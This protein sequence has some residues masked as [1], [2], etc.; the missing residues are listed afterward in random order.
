MPGLHAVLSASSSKRWLSCPPS[1][2]LEEKLKGIFGE[3]SSPYAEEGTQAH[4]VAELKLRRANGEINEFSYKAQ[5]EQLGDIPKEMDRA[6]DDYADIVLGKFYAAQK[7]SE[8]AKLLVEQRLDFSPWVPHGFGTG[9]AVIVSDATLEVAD[10]KF[11]K[12]V[13]IVAQ[14]N[15]QARLYGLGA[16]NALGELYGFTHVRNTIIQPRVNEDPVTEETLTREELE[17]W[18]ESIRPTAELAWKGL[19]EYKP[20]DHC[21]FCAARAL[22]AA[23]AAEAMRGFTHGFATPGLIDDADIP[24]ILEVA[25]VAESW[26]RDVRA[27]ARNQALRGQQWAG[28][29]LVR[30]RKG[31]RAWKDEEAVREQLIRAGYTEEQYAVHK[32][33]PPGEIE[34][35]L[36]KQAFSALVAKYVTQADGALNLVPESDKRIEFAAADADFS[37]MA[38]SAEDRPAGEFGTE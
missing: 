2:R 34:K 38:G 20:G 16:I 7:V 17:T 8:D 29:K 12:G 19:G 21:K 18:G 25:D 26:I 36:G 22:C 11:G 35:E 32:L 6:T 1:A 15:P 14:D 13:R 30:G 27:Y 37:D 24:G 4:A 28:F 23:R 9:D 3:K 5:R 33:R 10:L 31:N